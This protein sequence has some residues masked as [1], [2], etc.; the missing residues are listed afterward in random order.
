VESFVGI[1]LSH[2][3]HGLSIIAL[4]S[5]TRTVCSGIESNR[6]AFVTAA[7]HVFSPAGIFLSAPY[8][9]STFALLNFSGYLLFARSFSIT[10]HVSPFQDLLILVSGLLLGAAT[11]IRSNGLLNGL[12]FLEEAVRVIYSMRSGLN[13]TVVRR[14]VATGIGGIWIALGFLLPQYIA[15]REF[16][17]GFSASQ[18]TTSRIW[19]E[20]TLPSI[21]TFVQDHY[22]SVDPAAKSCWCANPVFRNV[23]FLRYWT[24]SNLPLFAI[25]TP[26]LAILV[27]SS[28]WAMDVN[29]GSSTEIRQVSR[30]A[31]YT[32]REKRLL[33]SFAVPQFLLAVLA[34]SSYH[35]QVIT[36]LSS[37]YFIWYL[38]L[39]VLLCG[40]SLF[41]RGSQHTKTDSQM[42]RLEGG[43]TNIVRYIIVYA[44][45]QAVLFSSFLPPA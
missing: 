33:R 17:T 32:A 27:A 13:P 23:G 15:F 14:L 44:A 7:L 9:E 40:S 34:V 11:T 41:P 45:V 26:M 35:V 36:R 10:E 28:A 16:C 42:G 37:G 22:W 43:S 5:L 25:A 39:S 8:G 12:L 1:V 6:I 38:W 3:A 29:I 20:R 19:C 21:Y 30:L 2:A 24:L 4:Y 18:D 31:P